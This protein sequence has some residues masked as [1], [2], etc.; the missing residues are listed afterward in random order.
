METIDIK[1]MLN[2][3][4][5]KISL[6]ILITLLI[7]I[8]GCLYG[9][10]IEVP[11]YKSSSTIVLV[12]DNSELTY[13]EVSL[14]KNLVST[15]AEIVKSKRILNQVKNNLNLDYSY[16]DLYNKIEVTSVT[17]TEIIKITVTDTNK[18]NAKKIANET[19]KVFEDEIPELYSISNVNI[20]DEAEEATTASNINIPKQTILFLMVGLVLGLGLVF[21]LYYFDRTVKNAEQIETKINLPVLGTVQD[22]KKRRINSL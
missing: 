14:N 22:Y 12:S 5:N 6:I 15:Y 16:G 4:K 20:L 17:N 11:L 8:V 9:I 19:A 18:K 21:V 13:N 2:Y 10:F 1:E 3:F 7:G